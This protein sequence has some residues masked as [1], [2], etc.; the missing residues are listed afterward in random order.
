MH[1]I[2]EREPVCMTVCLSLPQKQAKIIKGK[3][4]GKVKIGKI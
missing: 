4:G 1:A 2:L 3:I